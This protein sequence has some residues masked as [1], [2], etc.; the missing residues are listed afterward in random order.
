MDFAVLYLGMYLIVTSMVLADDTTNSP[1][2]KTEDKLAAINAL[3]IK[4]G[5]ETREQNHDNFEIPF[6]TDSTSNI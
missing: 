5:T 6:H 3:V 1:A 2:I 4:D